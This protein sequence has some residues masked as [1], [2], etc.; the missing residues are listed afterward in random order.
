MS[1]RT[2]G[3]AGR[4]EAMARR[5]QTK[6]GRT[7]GAGLRATVV[8]A[9]LLLTGYTAFAGVQLWQRLS[10]APAQS[11]PDLQAKLTAA[12][13]DAALAPV[14]AALGAADAGLNANTDRPLDAAEAAMAASDGHAQGIAVVSG[15][16]VVAV[17]GAIPAAD[18]RVALARTAGRPKPGALIAHGGANL[19]LVSGGAPIRRPRELYAAVDLAALLNDR[20][21][22]QSEVALA[23]TGTALARGSG[24][25]LAV[26][27]GTVQKL[28]HGPG[29]RS[30]PDAAAGRL[31]VAP[32]Y[33]GA[34]LAVSPASTGPLGFRRW[35]DG[36]ISL[37]APLFIGIVL[38]LVLVR[39][40]RSAAQGRQAL[41]ESERRVRL[42]VEA[43]HCGIWEWRLDTDLVT[44]SDVTGVML[45][46]GGGGVAHGGDV[47]A[48]VAT[49][50]RERLRQAL[51][52]AAD[53][54]AFDVSF[55]VDR[56]DGR[57]TWIDARGQGFEPGPHGFRSVIGVALDVT[58]ERYAEHRARQAE[59]RLSDAIGSISEAFVLWSRNDRL[60][61]CNDTFRSFFNIEARL[62][63]PGS[64]RKAVEE[65]MAMAIKR[66]ERASGASGASEAEMHDGR[67]LHLSERP[68]AE[69]GAVLTATDISALKRQEGDLL[70]K[71]QA[72]EEN[73]RALAELAEKHQQASETAESASKAKSEFLA[74]MSHELRTP[75]NAIIGFS[76]I[77]Q[78]EMYGPVGH[79]RYKEYAGDILSSGQHLLA[80]INDILD[81][82]KI[83]AGKLTLRPEPLDLI[84][85]TEDVVRLIR[86]R[87]EAGGLTL[88]LDI[89]NLPAVEADYRALKQIL[90]NLLTNA[91]KFTPRGGRVEVSAARR[92]DGRI[93]VSVKD[94]GI[95]IA[96]SDMERLAKPFE[97]I[98]SQHSKT[99]QGT[100]LGLALTKSLVEGHGGA[101]D[102][103]SQA[104]VGTTVRFSLPAAADESAQTAAA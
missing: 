64:P 78:R 19:L 65:I 68:T 14:R 82:S 71:Q 8:F 58:E 69:G 77:M 92:G 74:N 95:G 10:Q 72:L 87:A 17:T 48:R 89:P 43:A 75:L 5:E 80:L 44:M 104:G 85:I 25:A 41:D 83:E 96:E 51:R 90:L 88:A 35:A 33:D 50:H 59:R 12:E 15:G 81:M 22:D 2:T 70:L 38:T 40:G 39:Q 30:K 103:Q 37:L 99:Q 42:A 91:V 63:K 76:E 57:F 7:L 24:L 9:L 55:R 27:A 93:Q 1:T 18:W 67:W 98:E 4:A 94:T 26:P 45:G 56:P 47:I 31:S 100:G 52:A 29:S 62:L 53:H 102:I 11:A 79:A 32:A 16:E 101:L 60:L 21:D 84:E 13:V 86:T 54:G 20:L 61:M 73:A 46:W 97:Q 3:R 34:L 23:A 28:A 66:R 49:E 6:G 36:L